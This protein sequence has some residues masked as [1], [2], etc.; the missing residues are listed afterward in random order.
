MNINKI[1]LL[2]IF[3]IIILLS[4][5]GYFLYIEKYQQ[6]V[7]EG[8]ALAEEHCQTIEPVIRERNRVF[9]NN[10]EILYTSTD[11]EELDSIR[12]EI[13]LHSIILSDKY[14]PWLNKEKTFLERW[15]T[16]LLMSN[17]L[18][19]VFL[20]EYEKYKIDDIQNDIFYLHIK[21]LPERTLEEELESILQQQIKTQQILQ[22]KITFASKQKDFKTKFIDIPEL[23][24]PEI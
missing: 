18:K 22:E 23:N 6:I 21:K 12:N 4:I 20:A 8:T 24:C 9:M 13:L 14:G 15:D 5:I 1:Q 11:A 7:Y 10:I 19:E 17:H 16:K 2:K 3:I